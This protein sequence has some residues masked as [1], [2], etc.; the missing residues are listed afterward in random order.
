M[1]TEETGVIRPSDA[2][3]QPPRLTPAEF[4]GKE[5]SPLHTMLALLL[6]LGAIHFNVIIFFAAFVFLP[7]PKAMAVVVLLVI[8]MLIPIDE[9]SNWGRKLGRLFE[10]SEKNVSLGIR[11]CPESDMAVEPILS[12]SD[13]AI[14]CYEE[15]GACLSPWVGGERKEKFVGF[16]GNCIQTG[17]AFLAEMEMDML[18]VQIALSFG[19]CGTDGGKRG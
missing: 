4:K 7:L 12:V 6:W 3:A 16:L 9:K 8:F 18:N 17:K 1:G 19:I 14:V 15:V 10:A 5:C 2:A 11:E 13:R